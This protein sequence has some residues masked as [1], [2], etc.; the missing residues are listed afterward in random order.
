MLRQ[1]YIDVAGQGK[2]DWWRYLL[3]VSLVLSLWIGLRFI[4]SSILGFSVSGENGIVSNS[5]N[6]IRFAISYAI[7]YAKAQLPFAAVILGVVLVVRALHRRSL[8]RVVTAANHISWKRLGQ[9]FGLYFG[10]LT[11][12]TLVEYGLHPSMFD[13]SFGIMRLLPFAIAA[14]FLAPIQSV[15]EEL[16]FRGYL[17]QGLALITK[18]RVFVALMSS[19]LYMVA[20]LRNPEIFACPPLVACYYFMFALLL[21]LVTFR[22]Q[23]LE[24]AIGIHLANNLFYSV[25]VNYPGASLETASIFA[26]KDFDPVSRFVSLVSIGIVFYLVLCLRKKSSMSEL[27]PRS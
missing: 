9:G 23:G 20:H 7:Y 27:P 2:N 13:V 24:C 21:V 18:R 11:F 3:A 15:A 12:A 16:F 26:M 4:V 1:D 14:L 17:G 6:E 19:L 5:E 8:L 10:L 22:T 25:F